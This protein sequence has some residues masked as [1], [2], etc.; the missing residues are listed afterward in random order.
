MFSSTLEAQV[1][2]LTAER[3]RLREALIEIINIANSHREFDRDAIYE[4]HNKA[5]QALK[6]DRKLAAQD[7]ELKEFADRLASQQEDLPDDF[8][9]ILRENMGKLLED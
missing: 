6:E 2:A 8:Q 4:M 7:K 9:K 1:A 3:D 5:K